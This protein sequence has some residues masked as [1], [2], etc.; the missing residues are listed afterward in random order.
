MR[1][2]F[3]LFSI[4]WVLSSCAQN[5]EKYP[6]RNTTLSTEKRVEDLLSRL[7]IEEKVSLMMNQSPAIERLGIPAYDWWNEA[8]HG[9]ARAGRATVFPQAIGMAATFDDKAVYET[10]EVISDEARA[11]YHNYQNN[12]EYERYKGLTFW[13]PNINIFRDPRWGRGMETYGEDPYLT[14]RMGVAVVKGLQGDDPKYFKTL[15]CAKHF[16][17]HSGPEWSRHSLN[18]SVSSRDLLET[19]LPSF[20]DLIKE[21]NVQQVMCAYNRL[22]GE[23]CCSS[24]KLLNGILRKEWGYQ[25]ITVSDCGAISDFWVKDSLVRRHETHANVT[26]ASVDAVRSGTDLECGRDYESLVKAIKSGKI[27]EE[28][29]NVSLRRLLT[30]R[31][32]LGMFDPDEQVKWSKIPYSVVDS[33]KHKEKALEMAR[34][35]IVLLKNRNNVLPLSKSIKKIA[36]VGPNANDSTMLWGNYNGFPSSTVTILEGIRHKV[37]GAELIYQKGCELTKG[38]SVDQKR[39]DFTATAEKVKDAD[40][41]IFAGGISPSLEGEEMPVDAPGFKKGDRTDIELPA[42]QLELLKTLKKTG[43]PIVFVLCTGSAIALNWENENLDAIVNGWY[44]GQAAG[45][46]IADVI[47]GDYNPA[48]RLPVTFY[49]SVNQLGDFEDYS[50]KDRTYRYMT[51]EPLYPFG[52]G[53]SY[54]KFTY[55]DVSL[56]NSEMDINSSVSL[57][58]SV[59]NKSKYDGDEVIQVYVK[60]IEDKEGPIKTLKAFKRVPVKEMSKNKV[61]IKLENKA[62]MTYDESTQ[63]MRVLPGNYKVMVGSSS[64]KQDLTTVPLIIK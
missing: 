12:K 14:S 37:P 36:V 42:V 61:V 41:I 23:P 38:D 28:E 15:A 46:A 39:I 30:G 55:S 29:I 48:G 59:G 44:G 34:K 20:E 16:A 26:D 2:I 50:M 25:G 35:S 8:L 5:I 63:S 11:K 45:T 21:A 56:S 32:K 31:F 4:V 43:K 13:T 10:F 9:V 7:T 6:F 19:Y 27:S 24:K 22:D 1:K 40:V 54:S 51:S 64:M 47:F 53:L 18:V 52:Y 58:V 62:F 49:R 17:V 57:N 33:D 3:V 60:R